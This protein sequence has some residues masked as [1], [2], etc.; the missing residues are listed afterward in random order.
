VLHK[1]HMKPDHEAERAQI[2]VGAVGEP[3]GV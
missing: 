3:A 2:A 1:F